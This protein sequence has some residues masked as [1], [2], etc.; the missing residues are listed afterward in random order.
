MYFILE[1]LLLV[2]AVELKKNNIILESRLAVFFV[3]DLLFIG[4]IVGGQ[5]HAS[6]RSRVLFSILTLSIYF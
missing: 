4:M 1:G 3:D 6:D 2:G 5:C